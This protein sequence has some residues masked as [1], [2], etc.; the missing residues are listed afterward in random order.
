VELLAENPTYNWKENYEMATILLL[1]LEKDLSEQLAAVLRSLTHDVVTTS[2]L[3]GSLIDRRASMVF[4]GGDCPRYREIIGQLTA[5]RP[6]RPVIVV[7]RFPEN[8][9]W[10]DALELGAADYCGAPF[11]NVQIDWLVNGA[12]KGLQQAAA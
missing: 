3:E 2:S 4:A 5:A 11:E 8:A 9:R 7:N 10:L 6:G 12:L 1:G